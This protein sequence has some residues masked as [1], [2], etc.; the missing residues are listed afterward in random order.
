MECNIERSFYSNDIVNFINQESDDIQSKIQLKA[1]S[2]SPTPE[3]SNAWKEQ[4]PILK[5]QFNEFN[6]AK[7][8]FEYVIP[9]VGNRVD[10]IVLLKNIVFILEFKC[11]KIEPEKKDID[12]VFDYALDLKYFHKKSE[13]R[14]LVPI[15]ICTESASID[16]QIIL[17]EDKIIQPLQCNKSNIRDVVKKVISK[18]PNEPFL[19]PEE[20]INSEYCPVPTIIEAAAALYNN[21]SVEEISRHDANLDLTTK[22]LDRVIDY[23]K[24][25]LCKSICFVTGVPGAGKTLI[26]LDLAISHSDKSGKIKATYLSGNGPLVKVLREALARNK[27]EKEKE[28]GNKISKSKALKPIITFICSIHQYRKNCCDD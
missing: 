15:L 26:G 5:E 14:L 19:D 21:H 7:M 6:D 1:I 3:Q 4:I 11:G 22:E 17:G 27:V 28:R 10:N 12:Q 16:N 13:N 18:Y 8:I 25:N 20:W 2:I 23:S 9:R 24:N